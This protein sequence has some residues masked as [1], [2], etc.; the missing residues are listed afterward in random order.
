MV[1]PLK[2][3]QKTLR[4]QFLDDHA[5]LDELRPDTAVFA[6]MAWMSIYNMQLE[7]ADGKIAIHEAEIFPN[8]TLATIGTLFRFL[9]SNVLVLQKDSSKDRFALDFSYLQQNYQQFLGYPPWSQLFHDTRD[10]G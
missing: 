7:V 9:T 1:L 6:L 5:E 3:S 4:I 2:K 8:H 10:L